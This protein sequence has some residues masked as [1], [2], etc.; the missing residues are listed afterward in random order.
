MSKEVNWPVTVYTKELPSSCITSVVV[1]SE[2]REFLPRE[3]HHLLSTDSLTQMCTM[4]VRKRPVGILS[5]SREIH[6]TYEEGR[7]MPVAEFEDPIPYGP[8]ILGTYIS[9]KGVHISGRKYENA[10]KLGLNTDVEPQGFFGDY[11]S[12]IDT[13]ISNRYLEDGVRTSLSL[14]YVILNSSETERF[15]LQN[16]K[17]FFFKTDPIKWHIDMLRRNEDQMAIQFRIGGTRDR[18]ESTHSRPPNADLRKYRESFLRG[19]E[20]LYYESFINESFSE[21]ADFSGI[22]IREIREALKDL[23]LRKRETKNQETILKTVEGIIGT[24]AAK[25]AL[26][27]AKA[28]YPSYMVINSNWG[29]VYAPK[30]IDSSLI[31]YDFESHG[32]SGMDN[33]FY[34]REVVL[35]G[36]AHTAS[37]VLHTYI[38]QLKYWGLQPDYLDSREITNI[39]KENLANHLD[40]ILPN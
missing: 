15:L 5:R 2:A 18:L 10:I 40:N 22:T 13:Y 28:N 17:S 31:C 16:W 33:L 1:N 14:G 37:N 8:G 12:A 36:S 30:D 7:T 4:S 19:A 6:A 25:I 3:Y 32:I 35:N 26:A 34:P 39:F 23:A 27:Q 9:A 21:Y 11:D 24:E 20:L 38:K 29:S